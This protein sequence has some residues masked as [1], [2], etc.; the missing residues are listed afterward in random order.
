MYP[1]CRQ[2]LRNHAASFSAERILLGPFGKDTQSVERA[3]SAAYRNHNARA[4][5]V[6]D[7]VLLK[8]NLNTNRLDRQIDPIKTSEA[9][10]VSTCHQDCRAKTR[11]G[12]VCRLLSEPGKRRCKFHGGMPTGR[13]PKRARYEFLRH[14]NIAV[15]DTEQSKHPDKMNSTENKISASMANPVE[16]LLLDRVLIR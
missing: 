12:K 5:S 15:K 6:R 8:L 7:G 3:D 1:P 13:E 16:K 10:R 11:K 4:Q 14:R 2:S 9:T